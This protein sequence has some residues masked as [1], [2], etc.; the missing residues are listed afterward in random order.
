MEHTCAGGRPPRGSSVIAVVAGSLPCTLSVAYSADSAHWQD[1]VT[2]TG[3]PTIQVG[4]GESYSF[5]PSAA[6][7]SGRALVFTITNMPPWAS[8]SVSSGTLSGTPSADSAGTYPDIVI[9]VSDGWQ[10]A[11]LAPF[12][13]NV[14]PGA[15]STGSATV[16]LIPPTENVDGTTLTDLAGVTIFYGPSPGSLSQEVKVEATA[17][18]SY[19]ITNLASGTWYF[20]GVAYTTTGAQSAMSGLVSM[21]IP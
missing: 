17:P 5:T 9:T 12:S 10:S 8:F 13:I 14:S 20:G 7:T 11:A 3:S 19:T 1:Q 18:T 2:I 21:T 15:S 4:A 16:T 6:D